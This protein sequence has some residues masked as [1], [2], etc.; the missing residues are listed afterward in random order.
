MWHA[1]K[2]TDFKPGEGGGWTLAVKSGR[3]GK[4]A[5]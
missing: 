1:D 3:D 4:D 2:S 5:K